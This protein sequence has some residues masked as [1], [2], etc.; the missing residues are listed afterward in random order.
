VKTYVALEGT[1]E[2]QLFSHGVDRFRKDDEGL[3]ERK[4]WIEVDEDVLLLG[5][6][7]GGDLVEA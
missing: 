2:D 1:L 4:S 5:G 6:A 7:D 3:R